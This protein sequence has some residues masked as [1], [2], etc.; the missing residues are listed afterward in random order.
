MTEISRENAEKSI[1]NIIRYIENADGG[2]REGLFKT[3]ERVIDSF[4]EIFS[5]YSLKAENILN[6]TFNAE[7]YDGI[8]LLKNMEFHSTCEH[9]LQPFTGTA[10][11]AVSY[12][13][14]TLPTKA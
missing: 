6:S 1:E 10:H 5:G 3:P 14:L 12:T 7:G 11:I 4:D 13:H 2:L 8:V 9:H